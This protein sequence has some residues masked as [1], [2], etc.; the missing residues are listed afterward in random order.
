[1][2][3]PIIF[4]TGTDTDVGKT[5]VSTLLV[6]KWQANY[7]K[8]VQT[9]IESD[10]GDSVTVSKAECG[11]P[12]KPEIYSPRYEL[13]KPLSPYKAMDYEPEV[14]IRLSDF[15]I[16]KGSDSSPLI[17]EG[18][19]GVFVPLTRNLETMTD[20]MRKLAEKQDRPFKII[21]VTR[22][23]LGTLN[24]TLLT[25]SHL[26]NAGLREH[27]MGVIVNGE[28]NPD[29]V[30]VFKD[31]GLKILAEVDKSESAAAATKFIPPL[32]QFLK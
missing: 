16:P 31:Y 18:A 29:N 21:V 11:L 24:H 8:P 15:E 5:F 9:G 7:W 20:L 2:Q 12:W 4:V 3:Q 32:C 14:D 23:G 6:Y 25:I 30:Q 22:S 17:V 19:G 13:L 27:I 1:M 10:D 28:R 26:Q